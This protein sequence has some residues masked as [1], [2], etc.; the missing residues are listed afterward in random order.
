MG[1]RGLTS[2]ARTLV[3]ADRAGLHARPAMRVARAVQRFDAAVTATYDGRT[4]QAQSIL[5]LLA[6]NVPGR[7]AIA[8]VAK[9]DDAVACLDAVESA[10]AL[11]G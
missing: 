10:L 6:L 5:E 2:A 8:F 4:A 1:D 3:V 11:D 9:G 7:A